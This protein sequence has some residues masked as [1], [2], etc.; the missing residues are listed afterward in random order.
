M[1]GLTV[2]IL[3]LELVVRWVTP[4][5]LQHLQLDDEIYVVNRPGA[6]FT[7]ARGSEYAIPI[8]YN[9][10]GFRGPVPTR[11]VPLCTTRI[12]L[13]G[14]SQTEGLQV[15]LDETYGQVLQR[16]LKRRW[17]NRRFEVVNLAVSGYGT[18][19]ELLT[20]KRYGP[21]IRPDWVVL[22][23]HP[24]NDPS[25]N[26]RL[27]LIAEDGIG[28]RLMSPHFSPAHRFLLGAKLWIGSV[29]H[30]YAFCKP[31]VKQLLTT[32][33]L[34]KVRVI[35]PPPVAGVTTASPSEAT[36]AFWI[37]D[38]LVRMTRA[39]AQRLDA[40]FVVLTVPSGTQVVQPGLADNQDRLDLDFATAFERA[41]I[42]HVEALEPLRQSHQR[43]AA[44]FFSV[45]G[46]LNAVGH[47]VIGEMLGR[48]LAPRLV[49]RLD[50]RCEPS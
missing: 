47:R 2:A 16:E 24:L 44:P 35:E 42:M 3:A 15:H 14:D 26:V 10:W 43:R 21:A 12:V 6:R 32:P 27:P 40:Q 13:I 20:L 29:S 7:Y 1:T 31:R 41:G 11:D 39:E 8:T 18:H 37:T 5:P 50:A 33:W 49:E 17:P 48:W 19:Q 30:L 36:R 4:Q 45:D 9:T 23:F 22:G 28:V 46:H 34:T 38:A 25:H